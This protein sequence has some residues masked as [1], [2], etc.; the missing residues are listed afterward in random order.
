MFLLKKANVLFWV[1]ALAG[2][3]G[4]LGYR[5]V[6]PSGAQQRIPPPS[7][8]ITVTVYEM[9]P[10]T[11]E[12]W[13]SFFGT[14]RSAQVQKVTAQ[15]REVIEEINVE[16][17][18]TVKKGDVLISLA[19]QS[20]V[21]SLS[22]RQAAYDD[23]KSRYERLQSL[24]QAG[25]TSKQELD[26]ANVAV[27]EESAKLRDARTTVSRTQIRSA[28]NGVVV[29]RSV[30]RGE[31]AEPGR[32]LLAIA[33]FDRREVEMLISPTI[34]GRIRSGM[35]VL[36]KAPWGGQT[37]GKIFRMDPEADPA[38]GFF[39]GIVRLPSECTLIP[40]DYVRMEVRMVH[41]ENTLAVPYE[42][43][44]REDGNPHVFVVS[45]DKAARRDIV[46]GEGSGGFVEVSS[47]LAPGDKVVKIGA[48]SLYEG[49]KI[50]VTN[51][52]LRSGGGS[53]GGQPKPAEPRTASP[54]VAGEK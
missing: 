11:W 3:L 52:A 39:R 6:A 24:F 17:G 2:A 12:I 27:Q 4:F 45:G 36:V 13:R 20:Q 34:R 22:A 31:F 51:G 47:G 1:L 10:Q 35:D 18:D 48:G 26:K 50:V 44:L 46:V 9:Q 40:G 54:D 8:G 42:S 16:I 15:T 25:G 32:E 19:G 23:A 33:D 38:T 29:R 41:K 53:G 43:I 7:A 21:A 37:M 28:L 30:E 5:V 14:V 49:A